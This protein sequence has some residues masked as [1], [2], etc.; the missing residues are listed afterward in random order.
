M[1]TSIKIWA[2]TLIILIGIA[3][4]THAQGQNK[5]EHKHMNKDSA[6]AKMSKRLNLSANQEIKLKV[7]VKQ[8]HDEMKALKAS[9]KNVTKEEKRK[10]V[11]AQM[12]K[13]DERVKQVLNEQQKTEYDKMKAEHMAE[14]R[15][16]R[17]AHKADKKRVGNRNKSTAPA[18]TKPEHHEGDHDEDIIDDG[19]L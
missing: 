17:E 3:P 18:Q 12:Q 4:L 15:K 11:V 9:I 19:I 13:N 1:R 5:G 16:N 2:I 14:M 7:I 10:T 6:F 8:N